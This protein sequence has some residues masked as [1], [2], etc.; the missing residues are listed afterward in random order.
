M[1]VVKTAQIELAIDS[2]LLV[3][4]KEIDVTHVI[5]QEFSIA[6]KVLAQLVVQELSQTLTTQVAINAH[7]TKNGALNKTNVFATSAHHT[8]KL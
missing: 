8:L 5:N 4:H 1:V 7:K 6:F 3:E 2:I